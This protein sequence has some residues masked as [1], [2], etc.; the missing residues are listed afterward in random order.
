MNN[1]RSWIP[2]PNDPYECVMTI[3]EWEESVRDGL[4]I[5]DDGFGRFCNPV[6]KTELFGFDVFPSMLHY[7]PAY[8]QR[9]VEWTHI[10]WF[11]R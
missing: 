11:N 7:S 8:E 10:N 9:K 1:I 3:S 4:F 5:D 2:N 6:A